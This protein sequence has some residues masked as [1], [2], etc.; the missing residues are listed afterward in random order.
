MNEKS[1]MTKALLP[2]N[3]SASNFSQS[4]S[5]SSLAEEGTDSPEITSLAQR[6]LVLVVEPPPPFEKDDDGLMC[7]IRRDGS[8]ACTDE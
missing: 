4:E 5:C 6:W 2:G 7:L 1:K 8:H 3:T